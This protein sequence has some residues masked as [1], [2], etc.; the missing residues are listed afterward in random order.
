MDSSWSVRELSE[1]ISGADLYPHITR[2]NGKTG[3]FETRNL[4]NLPDLTLR[5]T[6]K[7]K[8]FLS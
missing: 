2:G 7:T 5:R 3:A 8:G 4:S 6:L 1:L